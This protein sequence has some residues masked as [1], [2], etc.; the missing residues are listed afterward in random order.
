MV[1]DSVLLGCDTV[2]LQVNSIILQ[3][4]AAAIFRFEVY[5]MRNWL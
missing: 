5:R 1:S 2:A 4:H 3:E